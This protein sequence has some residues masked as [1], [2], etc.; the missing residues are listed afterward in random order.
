MRV[1][2]EIAPE[3]SRRIRRVAGAA[4]VVLAV[5]W[6]AWLVASQVGPLLTFT[7]GEPIRSADFNQNFN[8]LKV[9]IDDADNK[10]DTVQT[11]TNTLST[12][13]TSQ[14]N[15]LAA[16]Q[17]QVANLQAAASAS[18]AQ[19][20]ILS[21]GIPDPSFGTN[22][23]LTNNGSGSSSYGFTIAFD[24]SDRLVVAGASTGLITCWRFL[25]NGLDPSFGGGA[26]FVTI[27]GSN[28][29]N[30]GGFAFDA[31]GNL[32]LG[33][34]K[35]GSFMP[36]IWR[37]LPSGDLDTNFGGTG[38]VTPLPSAVLG[39][40]HALVLDSNQRILFLANNSP[41]ASLVG[42]L[43][44][45]GVLDSASYAAPNGT[46]QIGPGPV[47]YGLALDASG[48]AIVT[49]GLA[50]GPFTMNVARILPGG[51]PDPAFAG[52]LF[53]SLGLGV[54]ADAL[55]CLLD[56]SGNI[57]VVGDSG[58]SQT[59]TVWR[60]TPAGNLDVSFGGGT[61]IVGGAGTFGR[62]N[63]VVIDPVG[64]IVVAGY[65]TSGTTR[66]TIWRFLPDGTPDANFGS[67]GSVV[68]ASLTSGVWNSVVIDPAGRIVVG[69]NSGATPI[70]TLGRFE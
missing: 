8:A 70:M 19:V 25:G 13:L 9:A 44:P 23:I 49:G 11:Q 29:V 62:G 52:G 4:V 55:H 40:M 69:G 64:R 66:P 20:S 61:G 7:P 50:F 42:R 5:A 1:T 51:T 21:R 14:G 2:I 28:I 16:L 35:A 32:L 68:S 26:G 43:T 36:A 30:G 39:G 3:T 12:T 34:S 57:V 27:S 67:A 37:L 65:T 45:T 54:A 10:V 31:S 33:G 38:M 17:A 15:Q 47:L 56:A 63:G 53:T 59:M 41:A 22:G 58:A 48:D 6:P 60:I 18:V 24:A 46:L